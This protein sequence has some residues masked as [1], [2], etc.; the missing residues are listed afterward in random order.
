[1]LNTLKKQWYRSCNHLNRFLIYRLIIDWISPKCPCRFQFVSHFDYTDERVESIMQSLKW[2]LCIS[3]IHEPTNGGI[4][5]LWSKC[6]SLCFFFA[7]KEHQKSLIKN[8]NNSTISQLWINQGSKNR[9]QWL[10]DWYH[11]FFTVTKIIK[12]WYRLKPRRTFWW[13]SVIQLMVVNSGCYTCYH[14]A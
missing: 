9:F 5:M 8:H 2:I 11:S 14:I 7:W 12:M 10:H 6:F 4:R 3:T 1:M 13:N